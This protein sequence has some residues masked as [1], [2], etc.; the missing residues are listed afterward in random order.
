[1]VFPDLSAILSSPLS[2]EDPLAVV[3][4]MELAAGSR[5]VVGSSF[6]PND[7]VPPRINCVVV[8]SIRIF[9]RRVSRGVL[10]RGAWVIQRQFSL[11]HVSF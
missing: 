11:L 7:L 9:S 1:M 10:F 5:K 3:V 6:C 8:V 2:F 4:F